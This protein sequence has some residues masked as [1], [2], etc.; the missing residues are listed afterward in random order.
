VRVIPARGK[1][2]E[3]DAQAA[4]APTECGDVFHDKQVRS[5]IA[6]G[7]DDFVPESTAG[8][9]PDAGAL[10][11]ATQILAREAGGDHVDRRHPPPVD[12]GDVAQVRYPRQARGEELPHV[13][14]WVGDPRD[15]APA[16]RGEHTDIR[17]GSDMTTAA[18]H[19]RTASEASGG[20]D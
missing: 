5:K 16:E 8:S 19:G 14:V 20:V 2:T 6:N 9:F 12:A 7:P 1:R 4:R 3:D 18:R 11:R 17:S 15:P 13:G 10:A